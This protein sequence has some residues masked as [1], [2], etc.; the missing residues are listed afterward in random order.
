MEAG[1]VLLVEDDA[2]SREMYSLAFRMEGFEVVEAQTAAE[3]LEHAASVH[4]AVVVADVLLPGMDGVDLC[5]RLRQADGMSSLPVVAVT[6]YPTASLR[7]EA[8]TTFSSILVKPCPPDKLI[9][10][11]RRVLALSQEK[12]AQS[13][14]TPE[15]R[16][17][18]T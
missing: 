11:V 9:A 18:R 15:G 7:P 17:L 12:R 2:A 4:P 13:V 1:P 5:A 8:A 3:A 14:K 10:E 16:Y 6:G